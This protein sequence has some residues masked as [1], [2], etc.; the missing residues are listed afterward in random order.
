MKTW[1]NSWTS[2]WFI[3]KINYILNQLNFWNKISKNNS[4]KYYK[5]I[6][7]YEKYIIKLN[8]SSIIKI[9][10]SFS[11]KIWDCK[12]WSF[13]DWYRNINNKKIF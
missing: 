4:K 13:H 1:I 10:I 12:S 3:N 8:V 9:I 5:I 7:N 6:T 11:L 2:V